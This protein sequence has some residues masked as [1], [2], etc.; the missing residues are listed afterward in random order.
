MISVAKTCLSCS[1]HI[2]GRTDKKFCN[3]HC[4]N[5]H[6]NQLNSDGNSCVRNINHRLRRNRRILESLLPASRDITRLRQQKL[7]SKGFA[8]NYFTHTR[9][10]KKG[11]TY[12]FCYDYGWQALEG[13][14]VL[15]VRKRG[16][17][18]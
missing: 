9:I 2:H 4:R 5:A 17:I 14:S 18:E 16:G 13:D 6:N 11:N 7:Y 10:T 12:Y 8:F 1:K 3:D 15:I